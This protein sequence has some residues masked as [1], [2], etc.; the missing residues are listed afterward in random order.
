MELLV[1]CINIK[2]SKI[3][4][5]NT[6]IKK[7]EG[8]EGIV[9]KNDQEYFRFTDK[10][11]G[12]NTFLRTIGNTTIKYEN[13]KIIYIDSKIN[14]KLVEPLKMDLVRDTNFGTFDIETA[15]DKNNNFIPIS[16]G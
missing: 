1:P 12:D 2:N 14:S 11:I 8:I 6:S 7:C 5:H 10:T 4:I 13:N 3:L 9:Y 16:C 15:L